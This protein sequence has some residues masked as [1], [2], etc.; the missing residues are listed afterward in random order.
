MNTL[1]MKE[2]I[3]F[4]K[5]YFYILREEIKELLSNILNGLKTKKWTTILL[6]SFILGCFVWTPLFPLIC[7]SFI[8]LMVTTLIM[9]VI[10]TCSLF[11]FIL[12]NLHFYDGELPKYPILQL[13]LGIIFAILI[14]CISTSIICDTIIKDLWL[15]PEMWNEI[16]TL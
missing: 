13:T 7:I 1:Y 8:L 5:E 16:L 10:L 4:I 6:I 9:F 2:L 15:Q 12:F 11:G 14:F 3:S